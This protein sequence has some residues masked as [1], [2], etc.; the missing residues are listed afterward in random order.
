VNSLKLDRSFV[1]SITTVSRQAAVATAVSQM[2]AALEFGSVAE[3]IETAEQRDL[4]RGLGYEYGQGYLYSRPVPA[5]RISEL[6]AR[7]LAAASS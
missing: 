6:R 3:G 1:E 5:D 2:A 7:G 4:L